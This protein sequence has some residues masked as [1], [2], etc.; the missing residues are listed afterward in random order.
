MRILVGA[1]FLVSLV[2]ANAA[3][4]ELAELTPASVKG[5]VVSGFGA[6]IAISA[7]GNTIIVGAPDSRIGKNNGVGLVYVFEKPAG[8]WTNMTQTATLM[9]SDAGF[10]SKVGTSVSISGDTVVAGAPGLYHD[11]PKAYVFVKPAEGWKSVTQT[12]EL[13]ASN[14]VAKDGFGASI[15]ISG[16]TV[17]VGE[18]LPHPN[19]LQTQGAVYIFVEPAGG[20]INMTETAKLT[21]SDGAKG[22]G[23]GSG[24]VLIGTQLVV[25]ADHDDEST[26]GA[27][28]VFTGSGSSWRQVAE[29]TASDWVAGDEFGIVSAASADTIV[30]GMEYQDFAY[31]AAYVFVEPSA[32]W[33]NMTETAELSDASLTAYSYFTAGAVSSDGSTILATAP[34]YDGGTAFL[35]LRPESGWETSSTPNVQFGSGGGFVSAMAIGPPAIGA[36]GGSESVLVFG[37]EH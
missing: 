33:A 13:T 25:G 23:F 9:A 31:D 12:A 15:S 35:F 34:D 24:V 5:V 36:I 7:D 19:Q 3:V 27:A 22:D 32:G 14:E 1:W 30:V 10:G 18:P 6:A 28:Y 26:P 37:R 17:A 20:W 21:A 29:L 2:T 16:S 8:G 11:V 4:T